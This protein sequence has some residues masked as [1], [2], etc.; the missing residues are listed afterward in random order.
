MRRA[1]QHHARA[2]RHADGR[3][4]GRALQEAAA[5]G[6]GGTGEIHLGKLGEMRTANAITHD[7]FLLDQ[8]VGGSG[9]ALSVFLALTTPCRPPRTAAV[10][11]I[12]GTP[13]E[14]NR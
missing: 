11:E 1:A 2:H 6:R 4:G 12:V 7:V 8:R 5:R 14:E 9:F 10:I 3:G 13:T